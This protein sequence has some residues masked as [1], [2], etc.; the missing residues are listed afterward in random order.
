MKKAVFL[1]RDGTINVDYG[2]VSKVEKF[3]I[4]PGA[5][6]GLKKMRGMNYLLIII[7]NQSGI[8]RGYYSIP[9]YEKVMETMHQQL[10][11]HG[12]TLDDCFYCPHSPESNCS[13]RKPGTKM[14]EEAVRKWDVNVKESFFIGDKESDIKAGKKSGLKTILV[15][16][17]EKEFGQN[18][19]VKNLVEAAGIIEKE[20]KSSED[21]QR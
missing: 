8:G 6:E 10:G 16:E 1:D 13:C 20:N 3:V 9:D 4:L 7:S 11:L 21:R 15:S 17:N 5:I 14:I 18:F 2:Y 12:I 19:R